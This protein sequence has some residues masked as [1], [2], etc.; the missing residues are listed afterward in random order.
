M[1]LCISFEISPTYGDLVFRKFVSLLESWWHI[2]IQNV[3]L[4]NMG[5]NLCPWI[6]K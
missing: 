2:K 6:L 3:K 4:G 5:V 1:R